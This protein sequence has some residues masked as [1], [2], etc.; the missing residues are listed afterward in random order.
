MAD[1]NITK[2][3]IEEIENIVWDKDVTTME[4]VLIYCEENSIE[5]EQI[6]PFISKIATI[7]N[8]IYGDAE[9]L[10]LVEKINRFPGE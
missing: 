10:N 3:F 7:K 8:A 4:A 5:P 6:A 1:I 2:A 9:K